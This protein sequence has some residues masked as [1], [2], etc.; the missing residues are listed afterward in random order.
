M[1]QKG[2][3]WI[4]CRIGKDE[5]VLPMIPGGGTVNDIIME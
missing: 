2:P 4:D 5:K 1:Q 3:S